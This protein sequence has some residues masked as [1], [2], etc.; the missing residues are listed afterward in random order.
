[1]EIPPKTDPRWR[2][3]VQGSQ[4]YQLKGLATRML[5]TRVR[6]M[7]SRKDESAI[8]DAISTAFDF[9]SKNL[10]STRSDIDAIFAQGK[11]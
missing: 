2:S 11:P 10:E 9:F 7:G 1:M 5:V 3:L 8:A 4:T 6:L